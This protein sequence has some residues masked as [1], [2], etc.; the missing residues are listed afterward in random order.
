M[1]RK[2]TLPA[3]IR[4]AVDSY[5]D[6]ICFAMPD[7]RPILVNQRMDAVVLS[8]TGH[9]VM[10]VLSLWEELRQAEKP[11]ASEHWEISPKERTESI[12]FLFSEGEIL[13]FQKK[14]LQSGNEKY[15]QLTASDI[16][17]LSHKRCT[18]Q[19][20]NKKLRELAFRQHRLLSEIAQVGREKQLLKT[21]MQIHTD[22]GRCL[23]AAEKL[24]REDTG[25]DA[26]EVLQAWKQTILH[27]AAPE[28][29]QPAEE[30]S[31]ETELLQAAKMIGCEIRITGERPKDSRTSQL[32]FASV[33]EALTNAVRHAGA[34]VLFVSCKKT[35]SGFHVVI[36]D[37]GT[38]RPESITES[39]GLSSLRKRLEQ[40]GASLEILCQD[41]VRLLA[42]LPLLS[43]DRKKEGKQK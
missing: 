30:A 6:G 19:Q 14:L 25:Q 22:L 37:N 41:G 17:D 33:R 32:L 20:N 29:E 26:E 15:I 27:F 28:E 3:A 21:K 16:T 43:E 12:L 42:E 31:P 2:T 23:I 36:S 39:G 9:T 7:G 24:L 34:D 8:L 40:E 1:K 11:D 13:Q 38:A 5:P 18:L 4:E 10:D 35:E